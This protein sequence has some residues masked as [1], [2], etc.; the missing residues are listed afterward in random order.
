MAELMLVNPRR[1][2]RKAVRKSRARKK[3]PVKRRKSRA[4]KR[5]T[6]RRRKK[7]PVS[8]RGI[9]GSQLMP[10]ATNAMGALALDV[11][12]SYLPVPM[13]IK[14]GAFRHVAKGIGAI[15]LGMLAGNFINKRTA[16]SM[17]QGALTVVMHGAM[18]EVTQQMMPNVPLGYY[19]PG[20][21]VGVGEYT[22]G[23]GA[24]TSG[25]SS[26]SPYL[27][28]DTLAKPFYGPSAATMATET[29]LESEGRMAGWNYGQ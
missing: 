9:V 16:R 22:Q 2:K 15:A 6:T 19:S 7:N 29:C 1:R 27:A 10:A 21:P 17:S 3:T 25:G 14:T 20:M 13:D 8:A 28:A 5:K 26:A 23:L 4:M 24:Y 18:R 11:V 12:W